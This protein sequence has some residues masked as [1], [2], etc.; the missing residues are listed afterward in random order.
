MSSE[1]IDIFAPNVQPNI[2]LTKKI[3]KLLE[4]RLDNDKVYITID[5][6]L[7]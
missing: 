5:I 1:N 7:L 6:K 3:N 4:T 2:H